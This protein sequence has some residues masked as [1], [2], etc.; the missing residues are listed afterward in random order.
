MLIVGL[1]CPLYGGQADTLVYGSEGEPV[2]QLQER[3]AA[4]GYYAMDISGTYMEHTQAAVEAF[5]SDNGMEATGEA[6]DA[7]Q[8]LIASTDA[9]PRTTTAPPAVALSY[10]GKLSSGS[11][12]ESVRHLQ[13][14]LAAL[15]YYTLE[16]TGNF[17]DNTR[18]AVK[19]FQRQNGLVEDGVVGEATWEALFHDQTIVGPDATPR[20]SP[21][22]A[23]VPYR[24]R[25]DVTNQVTTVYGLD[26]AGEY[27]NVIKHMI[28][29]TGTEKDP[30]APG[31]Y[32]LNGATSRWCYFPKWGTHAQYWTRIDAYN[33]FHSV[34][35]KSAN[36][37]TLS[38][39]SYTGLGNRASHGCIR[40][41]VE[42]AKWIYDNVGKGTEV[43]VFEGEWDEE[44]TKSQKIPPLDRSVM[45]PEPTAQPSPTPAYRSG[46]TPPGASGPMEYGLEDE[47]V[48]WLQN[49]LAEIGY[50]HGSLTGGY[51]SGTAD[52]VTRFQ[53]DHGLTATGN[54]DAQTL[55]M[56]YA[57]SGTIATQAPTDGFRIVAPASTAVPETP[58]FYVPR[59][60]R[61]QG[62]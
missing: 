18:E 17:L 32:V 54:A 15:G 49:R 62:S 37:M 33:A 9:A 56:I 40:L 41:L 19:A 35:Y 6:D 34:I 23:P 46:E 38:E 3:L 47:A 58:S 43:I 61:Q 5:Q 44:L 21:S 20:P 7:L 26:D 10:P 53:Q 28:C 2:R 12:G 22:P 60:E 55:E 51:Y 29:S 45:L 25:V 50:Y 14:R 27:T 11:E 42:D 52:A 48:F 16:I 39:G 4:L 30:T 13:S 59:E 1:A 24:I 31:T 8:R 57:A 36:S